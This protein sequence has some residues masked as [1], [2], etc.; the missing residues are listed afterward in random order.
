M[1]KK[2]FPTF[3]APMMAESTKAAFDSPDWIF[4]IKLDGYRAITVFDS[5]G[6]PHLG[7]ATGFHWNQNFRPS[8]R[9]YPS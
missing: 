6:Q 7:H 4:E 8:E 3:V 9:R 1:A 2:T 5:A